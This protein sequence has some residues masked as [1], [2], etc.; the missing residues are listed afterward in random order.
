MAIANGSAIPPPRRR[1]S[2]REV[3]VDDLGRERAPVAVEPADAEQP[4]DRALLADRGG[5]RG[6]GAPGGGELGRPR[7]QGLER[8]GP[9]PAAA[10]PRSMAGDRTGGRRRASAH[11]VRRRGSAAVRATCADP[12]VRRRRTARPSRS[13]R[14]P[15]SRRSRSGPRRTPRPG[16]ARRRRSTTEASP[17]GTAPDRW[18]IARPGTPEPGLDLV[19]DLPRA[20]RAPSTRTPRTPAR[21]TR[22]PACRA[23][24]SSWPGAGVPGVDPRPADERDDAPVLVRGQPGGERLDE[25]GGNGSAWISRIR[26]PVDGRAAAHRRDAGDLVPVGEGGRRVGVRAVDREPQRGPS[27]RERRHRLDHRVPGVVDGRAQR[28]LEA[29]LA[30]ARGLA[31]HREQ[32]DA[33][34]HRRQQPVRGHGRRRAPP[35]PRR[36]TSSPAPK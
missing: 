20:R 31:L 23:A 10:W 5:R 6:A 32:P 34:A 24:S 21:P 7:E 3:A 9:A 17:S 25:V 8:P 19:G 2:G 16:A 22:R 14:A 29:Q 11:Q 12:D 15:W 35:T 18:T 36:H 1:G 13:A 33:D 27:G 26:R 28:H 4:Q 30:H